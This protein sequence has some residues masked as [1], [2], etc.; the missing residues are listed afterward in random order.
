[1]EKK[2]I[3]ILSQEDTQK[4]LL[5]SF[6]ESLK[7]MFHKFKGDKNINVDELVVS[8]GHTEEEKS[9]LMEICDEIHSFNINFRDLQNS[10]IKDP[11]LTETKWLERKMVEEANSLANTLENRDVTEEEKSSLRDE[12][13]KELDLQIEQ[14]SNMLNKEAHYFVDLDIMSDNNNENKQ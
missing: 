14:E 4:G 5:Q 12:F 13:I 10:K 2:I 7:Q 6:Y 3:E 1:M 8:Q 9:I 11:S